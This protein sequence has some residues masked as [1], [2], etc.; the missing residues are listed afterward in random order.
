METALLAG[1]GIGLGL[2]LKEW[3][4]SYVIG[5]WLPSRP[6]SWW[7]RLLLFRIR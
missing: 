3:F 6:D 1:L 7:K 2:M 4:R 5:K